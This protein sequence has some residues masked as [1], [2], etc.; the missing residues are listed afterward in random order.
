MSMTVYQFQTSD[1]ARRDMEDFENRIRINISLQ[2]SKAWDSTFWKFFTPVATVR[3]T[4]LDRAFAIMNLWNADEEHL[5]ERH[6]S[7]H[8]LSVGDILKRDDKFYMVEPWGFAEI[9]V[10]A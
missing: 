8:S 9:Q 2:G 7:L 5:V 1:A 3:T 4:D 6:A 10:E